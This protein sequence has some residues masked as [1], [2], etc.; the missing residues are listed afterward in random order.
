MK[1]CFLIIYNFYFPLYE[2]VLR[3]RFL[4]YLSFSCRHRKEEYRPNW[5]L[6]FLRH[7]HIQRPRLL[8]ACLTQNPVTAYSLNVILCTIKDTG[9]VAFPNRIWKYWKLLGLDSGLPIFDFYFKNTAKHV[10]IYH[11]PTPFPINIWFRGIKRVLHSS[12]ADFIASNWHPFFKSGHW[13][14]WCS[15]ISMHWQL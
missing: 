11:F 8:N 14:F 2:A 13:C 7:R 1:W 15:W 10:V 3:L 4:K 9:N 5:F 12:F 6:T